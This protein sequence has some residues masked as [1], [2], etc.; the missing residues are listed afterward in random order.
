LGS[1]RGTITYD[2]R[3]TRV[4]LHGAKFAQNVA[5]AVRRDLPVS[6]LVEVERE[7]LKAVLQVRDEFVAKVD[8]PEHIGRIEPIM[9]T[10][11]S[12]ACDLPIAVSSQ[13]VA[14]YCT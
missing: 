3:G 5:E 13:L 4:A 7:D 11:P 1:A 12:W 9:T 2:R 8:R 10:P 14:R 6:A